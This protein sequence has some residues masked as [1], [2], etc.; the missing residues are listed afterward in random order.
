MTLDREQAITDIAYAAHEVFRALNPMATMEWLDLELSM[1]QLKALFV[2]SG[3]G[4]MTVGALGQSLQIQLPAASHAVKTLVSQG[5]ARRLKDENDLRCTY[6]ELTPHAEALVD[7]LRQG[8]RDAFHKLLAE[9]SDED[10]AA[11]LRGLGAMAAAAARIKLAFATP[12]GDTSG[13]HGR[14]ASEPCPPHT[15]SDEL[16]EV[17]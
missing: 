3:H 4:P 10:L 14:D 12:P 15:D 5:L 2:L 1:A 13:S 7:Q 17:L 16:T 11:G 6:I 9:L 8:R